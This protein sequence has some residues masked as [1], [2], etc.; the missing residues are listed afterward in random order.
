MRRDGTTPARDD[1]FSRTRFAD[2]HS[3]FGVYGVGRV[4]PVRSPD[5]FPQ[6][7]FDVTTWV[8]PPDGDRGSYCD[9]TRAARSAPA[10]RGIV[11]SWTGRAATSRATDSALPH[12]VTAGARRTRVSAVRA[13]AAAEGGRDGAP[14]HAAA[15]APA[16]APRRGLGH[17]FRDSDRSA[18]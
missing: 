4:Q 8:A 3:R 16:T 1:R 14:P 17:A 9:G 10:R 13:A 7:R 2:L 18:G 5:H 6:R 12:I 15:A 11:R